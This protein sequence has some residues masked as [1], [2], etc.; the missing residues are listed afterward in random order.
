[1]SVFGIGGNYFI[2]YSLCNEGIFDYVEISLID[3]KDFW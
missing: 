3:S 2:I 1:M